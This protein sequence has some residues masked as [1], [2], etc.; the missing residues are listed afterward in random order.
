MT[1]APSRFGTCWW[2]WMPINKRNALVSIW[3][4]PDAFLMHEPGFVCFQ[5]CQTSHKCWETT[6]RAKTILSF[7]PLVLG[8]SS[9][10]RPRV[11]KSSCRIRKLTRQVEIFYITHHRPKRFRAVNSGE[12]GIWWNVARLGTEKDKTESRYCLIFRTQSGTMS[13]ITQKQVGSSRTA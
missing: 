11:E 4:L 8:L 12:C 13:L 7:I 5:A 9:C 10:W 3:R 1:H 2:N 6:N